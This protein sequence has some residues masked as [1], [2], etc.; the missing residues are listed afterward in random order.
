[1]ARD[2]FLLVFWEPE[3]PKNFDFI[4]H[5]ELCGGESIFTK[6]KKKKKAKKND[7]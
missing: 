6:P 1:M 3:Y 7:K 2:K 4:I 5:S